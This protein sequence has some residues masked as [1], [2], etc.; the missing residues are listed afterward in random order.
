METYDEA[1][2]LCKQTHDVK[3]ELRKFLQQ[4]REVAIKNTHKTPYLRKAL[5]YDEMLVDMAREEFGSAD[6]RYA[7]AIFQKANTSVLIT[8][9]DTASILD[10]LDTAYAVEEKQTEFSILMLRIMLLKAKLFETKLNN[11]KQALSIYSKCL[12]IVQEQS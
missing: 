10:D 8:P 11:S 2:Q 3:P 4:A 1:I 6:S 12:L 7:E 5:H 9:D